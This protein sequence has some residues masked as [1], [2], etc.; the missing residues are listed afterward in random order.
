MIN[1]SFPGYHWIYWVGPLLG[2]LLACG[3]FGLLSLFEYSTVNPGQDFN[4]WE[5]KLGPGSWD[6][7]LHRPSRQFSDTTT[8]DRPPSPGG[9]RPHTN[10]H[11]V[12]PTAP[13]HST[14]PPQPAQQVYN[15]ANTGVVQN[16]AYNPQGQNQV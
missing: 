8:L 13:A 3:F 11:N 4:E 16:P 12:S 10:G 1:R 6:S 15:Q 5:S 2:S 9:S 7:S 14:Q